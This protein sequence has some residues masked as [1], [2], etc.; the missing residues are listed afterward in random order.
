MPDVLIRRDNAVTL[1]TID[2]IHRKRRPLPSH[3]LD[4]ENYR[5]WA[6]AVC[7]AEVNH[8]R[9]DFWRA[10][11]AVGVTFDDW[12]EPDCVEIGQFPHEAHAAA[13]LNWL[14]HLQ[15]HDSDRRGPWARVRWA[16]WTRAEKAAWIGRRR[17]L[18]HGF[19][20]CV[21]RYRELRA[22]IDRPALRRA[23]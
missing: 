20:R 3:D 7:Q 22:E 13:A 23:A 16:T 9:S 5:A 19:L 18:V 10:C 4:A 15:T 21:R 14:A 11:D 8:R 1:H 2:L 6:A 12:A 17:Y